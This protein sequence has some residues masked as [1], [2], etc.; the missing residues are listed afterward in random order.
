MKMS[1]FRIS[2]KTYFNDFFDENY[3]F[4]NYHKNINY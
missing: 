4:E 2:Q 3:D 1:S